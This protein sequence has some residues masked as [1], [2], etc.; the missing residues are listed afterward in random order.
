MLTWHPTVVVVRATS[1]DVAAT[2]R[3]RAACARTMSLAIDF[4]ACTKTPP[5]R[6]GLACFLS[7]V[8][9]PVPLATYSALWWLQFYIGLGPDSPPLNEVITTE[10]LQYGQKI[11]P[12]TLAC[13]HPDGCYFRLTGANACASGTVAGG[14]APNIRFCSDSSLLPVTGGCC[15]YPGL[16]LAYLSAIGGLSSTIMAILAYVHA[17]HLKFFHR[18]SV[19]RASSRAL[20]RSRVDV[21]VHACHG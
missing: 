9:V 20:K 21:H 1:T 17:F 14:D 8:I 18:T 11:F 10:Q 2:T 4:R 5:R 16:G 12:L 3:C 7:I 19:V 13:N 6:R 15:S